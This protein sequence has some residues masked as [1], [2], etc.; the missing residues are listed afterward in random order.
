METSEYKGL[1]M[2]WYIH[3]IAKELE[4][5]RSTSAAGGFGEVTGQRRVGYELCRTG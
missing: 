3:E 5:V 2:F 4:V 1:R